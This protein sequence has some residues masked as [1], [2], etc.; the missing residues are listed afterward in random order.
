MIQQS[1]FGEIE[2]CSLIITTLIKKLKARFQGNG[3]LSFD[4]NLNSF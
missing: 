3:R 2:F 4:T 1:E